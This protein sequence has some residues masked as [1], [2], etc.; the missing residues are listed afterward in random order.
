M[1][2]QAAAA[3]PTGAGGE[4]RVED[5]E[6]TGETM[7]EG[8]PTPSDGDVTSLRDVGMLRN[9][10]Q[11]FLSA[12]SAVLQ[13]F[14][15]DDLMESVEIVAANGD[16]RAARKDPA[17]FDLVIAIGA[18]SHKQ[19]DLDERYASAYF[20]S[21][22]AASDDLL[23]M[24]TLKSATFS[25]LTAFFMLASHRRNAAYMY[26]GTAARA[27]Q[28]LGLHHQSSYLRTPDA[29][30]LRRLRLW[31][32]ICVLDVMIS[33]LLGRLPAITT[34]TTSGDSDVVCR[35]EQT[36]DCRDVAFEAAF[37]ASWITG[38]ITLKMSERAQLSV[39]EA[40]SYLRR[41]TSW[42]KSLPDEIRHAVALHEEQGSDPGRVIASM[43]I[44]CSYYHAVILVTRPFLIAAQKAGTEAET[45]E[46]RQ[47]LASVSV[48]AAVYMV[49]TVC[50]AKAT[51]LLLPNT[52]FTKAWIFTAALVLGFDMAMNQQA[53]DEVH[54]AYHLAADFL[55]N[56]SSV[57]PHARQ[58]HGIV[59][60]LRRL[61]Q[62]VRERLTSKRRE[63]NECFVDRV[64][65]FPSQSV[66]PS[67]A[68]SL[69]DQ[70]DPMVAGEWDMPMFD[71]TQEIFFSGWEEWLG[72]SVFPIPE[73]L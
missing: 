45:Q 20:H 72:N 23:A 52:C 64:T 50:Q 58:Y 11:S 2:N 16:L 42:R 8:K 71:E 6:A 3:R 15:A 70:W 47:R 26:L 37:R 38:E 56:E 13:I 55:K 27:A 25:V 24:P 41:L 28:A 22:R 36:L 66:E 60:D 18:Q 40:E 9:Y 69:S 51:G 49:E 53:H 39:P 21:A 48:D 61:I 43:N 19:C 68:V 65:F 1:A 29:E 10:A 14:S 73:E 35:L 59:E 44:S 34:P 17:A 57:S 46:D 30:G 33:S 62:V 32:S 31:K 63:Q 4:S 54:R 7:F 12:T 67:T 5:P